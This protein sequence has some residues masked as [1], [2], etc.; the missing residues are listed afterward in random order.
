MGGFKRKTK[1]GYE[2]DAEIKEKGAKKVTRIEYYD[3]RM[4][5]P[6]SSEGESQSGEKK[7]KWLVDF[8]RA[9][10]FLLT[11]IKHKHE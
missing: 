3:K 6:N 7:K 1:T 2:M 10:L 8:P 5:K 4:T 11:S 9:K